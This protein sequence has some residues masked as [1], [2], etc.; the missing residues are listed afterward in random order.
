FK[1]ENASLAKLRIERESAL[2]K[3]RKEIADFEQQKAKELAR[4]EE[5][6]KEEMRKLQKERKVFEKYTTA[7]RTFPDKKEREEIQTLKQQIADLREDL[8]RKETKWSSTHSRLRSQ[9]E[10]LV[11]E[12]TDLRE[13]I[14]VM[15][16][17][18]LDAWKR[19]EAIESS[20]EVEKKDKLANTSVRFQNSQISSGTQVEKYKKN[21]LPMQG[22]RLH[23]LFIK[24]FRM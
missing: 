1:A 2:E 18:R 13:E 14:K 5:F 3:L 8:K 17:F 4:I 12:N 7:A 21:Y 20:L 6:K 10:M 15:E 19:A 24:H 9:I 16:R 23:D 11:R 22:K